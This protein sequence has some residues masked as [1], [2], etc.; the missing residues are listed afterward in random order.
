MFKIRRN[1]S[2]QQI[3]AVNISQADI[4]PKIQAEPRLLLLRKTMCAILYLA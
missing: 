4:S 3:A 2:A 1:F